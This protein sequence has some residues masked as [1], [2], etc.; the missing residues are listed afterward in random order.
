MSDI[1]L[2]IGADVSGATSGLRA[3]QGELGRT[4]VAAGQSNTAIAGMGA[5]MKQLGMS[6]LSSAGPVAALAGIGVATAA[7][8]KWFEILKK[9]FVSTGNAAEETAKKIKDYKKTVDSVIESVANE[10]TKTIGLLAVLNNETETRGRKLDA[11]K[12]LQKIQPEIFEGLKLEEGAV[13]GLDKAYTA[14]LLNLKSVISAKII[15]AQIESKVAQLLKIEGAENT[16]AQEEQLNILKKSI[17]GNK[18]LLE[19]KKA[20]QDTKLGGGF[21]TDKQQQEQ[22]QKLNEDIKGL[23]DKLT[24]FSK[25]IKVKTVKIKPEKVELDISASRVAAIGNIKP[26]EPKLRGDLQT[27]FLQDVILKPSFKVE[28][29][30]ADRK[31]IAEGLQKLFDIARIEQLS[32]DFANQLRNV[33][34]STIQDTIIGVADAA[35]TA[36]AGGKDVIPNL[37]GGLMNNL[38]QQIQELGKFLIRSAIQIK[39]AKE[40][41]QKLLSNPV[42]AAIVGIGLVALGALLK[43]QASKQYKG[44]ASGTTGVMEDGFYHVNERGRERIFLPRGSK[45]QPNNELQAYNGGGITLMPSIHYSGDGFRIMLNKVDAQWRRN[46]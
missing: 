33:V 12:E 16:K 46:N 6:I 20:L 9:D 17:E 7:A 22:V 31:R 19:I 40:A 2:V 44:F 4:A 27:I 42:A 45:V 11:I 29:T 35:G 24:E 23:F 39:T 32:E 5:N 14:Y 26:F 25:T 15:Q 34:Q 3:V 18:N 21:L 38:G 37:F 36:L 13:I 43:Q 30:E 1:K 10:T 8:V 41:F 28:I